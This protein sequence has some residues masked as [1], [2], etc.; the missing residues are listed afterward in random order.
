MGPQLR[1]RQ[2]DLLHLSCA[3]RGNGPRACEAR[4]LPG[5]QDLPS[6]EHDR[7]DD[8]R[9][10][11]GVGHVFIS[12]ARADE[13][14]AAEIADGIREAGYEVWRDDEL[15]AH[16]AYAEI[17]EERLKGAEAVVVLWSAEA[18][19]SQW[20]RAEADS[21]RSAGTLIQATLDGTVPPMPF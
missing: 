7:P 3:E 12:Y 20:V 17:I 5:Q 14:L 19:K 9:V 11:E 18:A 4:R 8:R 21:A 16:R 10:G 2:Q 15:P 1:H 6:A 13:D